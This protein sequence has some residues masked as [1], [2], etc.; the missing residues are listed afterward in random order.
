[1]RI[2]ASL[3][4]IV[5][6]AILRFAVTVNN[7]RGFDYH[8]AGMILLIVGAV[9]LVASLIW[10]AVSRNRTEVVHEVPPA[11]VPRRRVG[12]PPRNY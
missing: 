6:G 1:M 2:G 10:M 9:G 5:I 7:P 12:A 11:G 3:F 8:T 4:L